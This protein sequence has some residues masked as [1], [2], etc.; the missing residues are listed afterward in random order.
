MLRHRTIARA[1]AFLVVALWVSSARADM[2]IGGTCTSGAAMPQSA[3]GN[4]VVCV[5]G[6]WQYPAYQF[7]SI[8]ASCPGTGNVNLG[9]VQWTGSVLQYCSASGWT[10]MN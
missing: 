5:S 8:T 9:M 6:V 2:T 1:T 7:G 10:N 4:N 3:N